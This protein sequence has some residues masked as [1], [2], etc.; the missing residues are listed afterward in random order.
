MFPNSKT[1]KGFGFS[2]WD[3]QLSLRTMVRRL[4]L[5]GLIEGIDLIWEGARTS[6]RGKVYSRFRSC[7]KE[8]Q[9]RRRKK[10]L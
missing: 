3:D 5:Y 1:V 9:D 2:D 8:K 7:S 6:N 10:W 4:S